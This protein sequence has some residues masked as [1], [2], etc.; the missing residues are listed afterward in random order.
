MPW[1]SSTS[2]A[3]ATSTP[4]CSMSWIPTITCWAPAPGE[5]SETVSGRFG[6]LRAIPAV[7]RQARALERRPLDL[8]EGSADGFAVSRQDVV[9]AAQ[10]VGT[11]EDVRRVR[12]LGDQAERLPLPAAADHDRDP[13]PG[14][15]LGGVQ[16][17]RGRVM[18]SLVA[19]LRPALTG[20]HRVGDL[21]RLLEHL[22]AGREGRHREAQGRA[23]LLVPRRPDAQP[24]PA[25]GQDVERGGG[26]DPE[27]GQP[28]VD[29]ADHQAKARPPCV[30]GQEPER[31]PAL[32][33]RV[34]GRPKAPDLEEV[35]HDP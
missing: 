22:E 24:R 8:L 19:S 3:A 23:L 12:V 25:A 35:I 28:V 13:G 9:L 27:P 26:L 11:A 2:R 15:R 32:E 14:Q 29:A 33:H 7:G 31:R 5:R 17:A 20:E 21:E 6:R 4:G 10:Q 18:G 16:Q 1:T 34:L 30:G